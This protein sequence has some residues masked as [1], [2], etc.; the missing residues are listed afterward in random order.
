[1]PRESGNADITRRYD[2]HRFLQ[3]INVPFA[4][5]PRRIILIWN[6]GIVPGVKAIM[7]I[8]PII[9]LTMSIKSRRIECVTII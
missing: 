6:F 7:N 3:D 4:V 5:R 8:A 1:V 9:Y 2:R